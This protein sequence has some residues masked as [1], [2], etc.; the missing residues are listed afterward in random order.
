MHIIGF[1]E[2][3]FF[4]THIDVFV[5]SWHKFKKFVVVEIGLL[6]SQPFMKSHFHFFIVVELAVSQV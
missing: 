2:V 3:S 1:T 4:T 5:P 6:H